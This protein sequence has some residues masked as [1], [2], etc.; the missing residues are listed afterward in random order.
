MKLLT[1][2]FD[3]EVTL[4]MLLELLQPN[5]DIVIREK[6]HL[7]LVQ[8]SQPENSRSVGCLSFV[9][10]QYVRTA[11][12]RSSLIAQLSKHELH[13]LMYLSDGKTYNEIAEEMGVNIN[14]LRYYIKKIYR[15]LGVN[16]AREAVRVYKETFDT[17]ND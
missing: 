16:S 4:E 1:L 3:Q 6:G 2:R 11:S 10:R 17:S 9:D 15:I 12:K 13:I 7:D 8:K 14:N 5:F